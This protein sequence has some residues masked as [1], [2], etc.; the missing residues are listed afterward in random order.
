LGKHQ[1][2]FHSRCRQNN[3]EGKNLE[4]ECVDKRVLLPLKLAAEIASAADRLRPP[5]DRGKTQRP[6]KAKP[7][8]SVG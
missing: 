3:T 8:D 1:I 6:P 7:P 5:G 4:E 2:F